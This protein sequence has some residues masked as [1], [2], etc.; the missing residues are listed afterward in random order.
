M[1]EEQQDL[2][3]FKRWDAVGATAFLAI[4]PAVMYWIFVGH[5]IITAVS[6]GGF[7][8]VATLVVLILTFIFPERIIGRI[9]NKIGVLM[10][11]LYLLLAIWLFWTKWCA[12]DTA[13]PDSGAPT[14]QKAE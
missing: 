12:E 5:D 4:V 3:E 14:E 9:V 6:L 1:A 11:P 7:A 13:L 10:A 2:N 8:G